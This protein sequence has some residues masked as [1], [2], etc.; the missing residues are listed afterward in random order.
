MHGNMV[1]GI[2]PLVE[3]MIEFGKIYVGRTTAQK[4]HSQGSEEPF[5]FASAL[6]LIGL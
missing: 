4:L 2:K 3:G 6:G 1:M 5:D